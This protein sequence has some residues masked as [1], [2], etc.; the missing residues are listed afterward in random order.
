MGI[1]IIYTNISDNVTIFITTLY[2]RGLYIIILVEETHT[3]T[4]I[5][6]QTITT[7]FITIQSNI[8]YSDYLSKVLTTQTA[9]M[10]II[11]KK[12]L[13]SISLQLNHNHYNYCFSSNYYHKILHLDCDNC[14]Y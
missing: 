1:G 2:V 4:I 11:T 13:L 5:T 14:N 3:I 9:K 7:T 10:V 12:V 6:I 8:C